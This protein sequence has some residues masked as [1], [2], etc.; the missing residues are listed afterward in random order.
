MSDGLKETRAGEGWEC[1]K[2]AVQKLRNYPKQGKKVELSVKKYT[3]SLKKTVQTHDER[4]RGLKN[5]KS[6]VT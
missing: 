6:S 1:S 5:V 2:R 3:L 4:E